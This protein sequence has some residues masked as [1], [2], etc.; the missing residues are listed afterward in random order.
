MRCGR[1]TAAS[2]DMSNE[3]RQSAPGCGPWEALGAKVHFI[4]TLERLVPFSSKMIALGLILAIM[5]SVRNLIGGNEVRKQEPKKS[6]D[7][8]K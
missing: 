4:T 7:P 2:E 3:T 1:V 5:A 8:R 6:G